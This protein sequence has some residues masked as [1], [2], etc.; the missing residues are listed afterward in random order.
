MSSPALAGAEGDRVG[1]FSHLFDTS[2]FTPQRLGPGWYPELVWLHTISDILIWLAYLSIPL[3]LAFFA[4]DRRNLPFPRLI[5]LFGAFMVTCGFTHFL[6]AVTD[7]VPVYRLAGLAKLATAIIS[8]A[9]VIALVPTVPRALAWIDQVR[10]RAAPLPPAEGSDARARDYVIAVLAAAGAVLARRALDPLLGD[11]HPYILPI[12]AVI[13]IAWSGGFGPAVTT[14]LL[15]LLAATYLFVQPR[16]QFWVEG[17]PNQIGLGLFLFGGVGAALLGEAQRAARRRVEGYAADLLTLNKDLAR[18]Q[19]EAADALTQLDTFLAHAPVGIA[20]YDPD[21]RYVRINKYLADANRLPPEA[22]TG[23]TTEEV[24]PGFPRDV[25]A[26]YRRALDTGEPVRDLEVSVAGVGDGDRRVWSVSLFPVR[27]PDGSPL[28]LVVVAQDVTERARAERRLHESEDRLRAFVDHSPGSFYVKDPGGRYTLV[29][30]AFE[31]EAGR[32]AADVLGKTDADLF[33]EPLARRFREQD[34]AVLAAG[35]ACQWEDDFELNGRPYTVLTSKFP[36]PDG[37]VGGIATDLTGRKQAEQK[38]RESEARAVRAAAAAETDRAKLTATLTGMSQ[39]LMIVDADGGPP[40]MNPAGLA[41]HGF[42]GDR[43]VGRDLSRLAEFIHVRSPDGRLL[44]PDDWPAARALRG[45]AVTNEELHVRRRDTGREFIALY[46]A[47]P[48]RGP[49]GEVRAAVVTINDVTDR[50]RAQQALRESEAKFRAL[51]QALPELIW[52][53]RADGFADFFNQRWLEYTGQ[54][55][56]E[57]SGSGWTAVVHPDD[58]PETGREWDRAVRDG[59][60]YEVQYRIRRAADG[61]YRWFL[62]RAWPQRD[63]AGRVVRWLGCSTDID[64]QRREAE[65]LEEMVRDRTA[66]LTRANA[67]LRTEVAERRKAEERER[68][69]AVELLRSNGELEKFAYVASHDLQEPLRKI[70]AFGDRLAKRCADQVGEQGREYIDRMLSS[71]GRMRRLIDDLLTFS[72]VATKTQPF[73]PV[74]LTDV[75]ADVAADLELRVAQAGARLEVDPL[76]TVDGDPTQLR[77]L[78]QN[79]VGNALKFQADGV[80][81]V[82]RVSAVGWDALPAGADPPPPAGAGWRITVADNGIGFEQQFA[83]RIFEVFQRLHGRDRY[84][85]TGIGLAICRKIVERHGGV[86]TARSQ[87]G[88]GAVFIID[89]TTGRGAR[90]TVTA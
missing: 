76:P 77:Q 14:L 74:A 2:G 27:N 10:G 35:Q 71:A 65:R 79:L 50:V 81:P 53:C 33:P 13:L 40:A 73:T 22:H 36:L 85:G 12:L 41:L 37:A 3:V 55:L 20:F 68:A 7:Y 24:M 4:R 1:F 87:P 46:S 5:L 72:R 48:V 82:V 60:G 90:D 69:A 58:L 86:I 66:A 52:T 30:Q 80:P 54:T 57:S 43:D 34:Q 64:D 61:A 15:S 59:T 56:E 44:R 89:L 21:L 63:E 8:W 83:D 16:N 45:E 75:L 67:A 49:G 17:L 39:G 47:A 70:Q 29:N 62:V 18:S 84:E 31:Q 23:K 38:L 26:A 19:R 42:P 6:D 11:S 25:I 88:R 28:G 9:A 78:F 51:T 32:P